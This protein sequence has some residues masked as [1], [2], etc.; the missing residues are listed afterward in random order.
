MSHSLRIG[1]DDIVEESPIPETL[2]DKANFPAEVVTEDRRGEISQLITEGGFRREVRSSID[3]SAFL[4]FGQG[5]PSRQLEEEYASSVLLS[6][7]IN[8]SRRSP[9]S[10][11]PSEYNSK[12]P[13]QT[14]TQ[15]HLQL[16]TQSAEPPR[17]TSPSDLK[18][19]SQ[20]TTNQV[21]VDADTSHSGPHNTLLQQVRSD[22]ANEADSTRL[23]TSDGRD[24]LGRVEDPKLNA[25]QTT[26]TSDFSGKRQIDPN[27][28]THSDDLGISFHDEDTG[29]GA[30]SADFDQLGNQRT[31]TQEVYN[32]GLQNATTSEKPFKLTQVNAQALSRPSS[33]ASDRSDSSFPD[34]KFLSSQVVK[35]KFQDFPR[36]KNEG[37]A[38]GNGSANDIMPSQS[39]CLSQHAQ[40]SSQPLMDWS[41]PAADSIPITEH[42]KNDSNGDNARPHSVSFQEPISPP[43]LSRSRQTRASSSLQDP[44]RDKALALPQSTC[45]NNPLHESFNTNF[46]PGKTKETGFVLPK[47]S[48]V[49]N[50]VTSSPEPDSSAELELE[51]EFPEIYANDSVDDNYTS[52]LPKTKKAAS[53]RWRT[54][55][56]GTRKRQASV[57]VAEK[58][59]QAI[60]PGWVGGSQGPSRKPSGRFGGRISS[61]GGYH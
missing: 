30:A 60:G 9:S 37:S 35:T 56:T 17:I 39:P 16:N 34:I 11:A 57:P 50:L 44:S 13:M 2:H 40:V 6:N 25:S 4:Q 1:A 15:H 48:Q 59:E 32:D 8:G 55:Q 28:V 43:A 41:P 54:S 10:E 42:E 46:V 36:I 53:T 33:V 49:V 27:F 45:L 51:P 5:S 24:A 52:S 47:G 21:N 19:P 31:P 18:R 38:S 7:Q 29:L 61:A 58:P 22:R 26:S 3:R 14:G 23:T 20:Q 12:E